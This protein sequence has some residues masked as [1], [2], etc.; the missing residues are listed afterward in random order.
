MTK[1]VNKSIEYVNIDFAF[2]TVLPR[3]PILRRMSK[4]LRENNISGNLTWDEF[5]KLDSEFAPE[6]AKYIKE[7]GSRL[8]RKYSKVG[9]NREKLSYKSKKQPSKLVKKRVPKTKKEKEFQV[10][11]LTMVDIDKLSINQIKSIMAHGK[12]DFKDLEPYYQR[13][14]FLR[15]NP[16]DNNKPNYVKAAQAM[17]TFYFSGKS[18]PLKWVDSEEIILARLYSAKMAVQ[19]LEKNDKKALQTA[20]DKAKPKLDSVLEKLGYKDINDI[21]F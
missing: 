18:N 11:K 9:A 20:M 16:K 5:N 10:L 7:N 13:L 2:S 3:T 14:Q 4:F 8:Q 1:K 21:K 19:Y 15:D 6:Y 12:M 17:L